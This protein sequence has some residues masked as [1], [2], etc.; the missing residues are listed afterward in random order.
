MLDLGAVPHPRFRLPLGAQVVVAGAGIR[1]LRWA[2]IILGVHEDVLIIRG[3]IRVRFLPGSAGLP[4]ALP[5]RAFFIVCVGAPKPI[6][7]GDESLLR[8]AAFTA[9]P[10]EECSK[11]VEQSER[12]GETLNL[13]AVTCKFYCRAVVQIVG[14]ISIVQK[15]PNWKR[16]LFDEEDGLAKVQFVRTL[17]DQEWLVS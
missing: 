16:E 8:V 6:A 4:E 13:G 12:I 3:F 5:P 2:A 9:I 1:R 17:R 7:L 10:S 15:T 14:D 11:E